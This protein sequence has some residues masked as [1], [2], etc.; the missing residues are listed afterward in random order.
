M[1]SSYEIPHESNIAIFN[2]KIVCIMYKIY[3]TG[4]SIMTIEPF[5]IALTQSVLVCLAHNAVLLWKY[6]L[7][8]SQSMV[9]SDIGSSRRERTF[10]IDENPKYQVENNDFNDKEV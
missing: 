5:T 8:T 3:S 2:C 1:Q 6:Q 7:A 4:L 9:V 10:H